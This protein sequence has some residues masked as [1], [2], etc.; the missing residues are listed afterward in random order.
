[1]TAE[2]DR[3]AITA[4]LALP[5]LTED[6]SRLVAWLSEW[7]IGTRLASLIMRTR[8]Q[9]RTEA[10]V[11]CGPTQPRLGPTVEVLG[12]V[13]SVREARAFARGVLDACDAHTPVSE[14]AKEAFNETAH[15]Y[16]TSLPQLAEG[17]GLDLDALTVDQLPLLMAVLTEAA[18]PAVEQRGTPAGAS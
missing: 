3:S 15:H 7:G 9:A 13:V 4:A 5:E 17:V 11:G 18:R 6:E 12:R 10:L 8:E 1:M 2:S 16:G 14:P